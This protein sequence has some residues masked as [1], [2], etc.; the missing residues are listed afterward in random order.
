MYENFIVCGCTIV[1]KKL[2]VFFF[3][4]L[5]IKNTRL[6]IE[7]LTLYNIIYST[8]YAKT[9]FASKIFEHV[10]YN[11][12]ESGLEV[13]QTWDG[14]LVNNFV[15]MNINCKFQQFAIKLIF[16]FKILVFRRIYAEVQSSNSSRRNKFVQFLLLLLFIRL[17]CPVYILVTRFLWWSCFMWPWIKHLVWYHNVIY[18]LLFNTDFT[19]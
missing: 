6:T 16:F 19:F 1:S 3:T 12:Q 17:K 7:P 5:K 4:K 18:V 9:L 13:D 15:Q 14:F 11:L 8:R 2:V 10:T